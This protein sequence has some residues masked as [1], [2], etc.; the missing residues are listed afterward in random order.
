MRTSLA[1]STLRRLLAWSFK[2]G[3]ATRTSSS[4]SPFSAISSSRRCESAARAAAR[5]AVEARVAEPKVPARWASRRSIF[6]CSA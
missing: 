2:L 6:S 5:A 4:S 1:S 3:S